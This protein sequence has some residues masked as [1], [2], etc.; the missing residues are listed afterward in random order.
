MEISKT[1]GL[2]TR[3]SRGTCTYFCDHETSSTT[4]L[5]IAFPNVARKKGT[6][7]TEKRCCQSPF[8]PL[9]ANARARLYN[10]VRMKINRHL[11]YY[12]GDTWPPILGRGSANTYII[13]GDRLTLVDPGPAAGPHLRRVIRGCADDGLRFDNITK[14]II[15]HAHPDHAWALPRLCRR[16]VAQVYCHALE[17]K[18]LE[19]PGL[20]LDQEYDAL[21]P[22]AGQVIP[23]P[24]ALLMPIMHFMFGAPEPFEGAVPVRDGTVLNCG[25]PAQI[26]EL[27]GHRPGEIGVYLPED[28]T[29]I[30]GDLVNNNLYDLPSLNMPVSDMKQAVASLERILDMDVAVLAPGHDEVVTGRQNIVKWL[31]DALERCRNMQR[32]AE[33]AIVD[34][35]DIPLPRLGRLLCG[36][37]NGANLLLR[38]MLPFIVL[39][40]LEPDEN[41][42]YSPQHH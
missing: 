7:T 40:S 28:K 32:M 8:F 6:G 22:F 26:M 11:Y 15:T 41:N 9:D 14:V 33:R 36:K 2:V 30:I 4:P 3:F 34:E 42:P 25:F 16:L 19:Q 31:R 21:G 17:K 10:Q 13:R 27:P 20:L 29:L 39:K 5:N 1:Q 38:R 24:R 12:P 35:P 23:L 37:N 18:V